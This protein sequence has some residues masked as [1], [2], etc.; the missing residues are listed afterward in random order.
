MTDDT[1]SSSGRQTK[2]A[3][4]LDS[5][6]LDGTGAELARSWRGEGEP[7]RSLRELAD[8]LNCELLTAALR[9]A[10]VRPL[11]GEVENFYRLL[12][13]DASSGQ[14][15]AAEA[16]LERYG[17][18]VDQLRADFVSHQA[19]HTYLQRQGVEPPTENA[20]ASDSVDTIQRTK[21]RLEA[22]TKRAL[23]DRVSGDDSA[24]RFD[25]FVSVDVY[26]EACNSQYEATELLDGGGCN[27]E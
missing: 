13:G 5:Y 26:C 25:V 10:E 9:D 11:D 22:I 18:D 14:Q 15:T 3:R 24:S 1:P 12:T 2:V 27:C 19:V 4:L 7:K 16:K 17:V 8:Y 6:G 23:S 21:G 20:D